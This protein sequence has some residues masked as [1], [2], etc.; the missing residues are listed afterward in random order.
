LLSRFRS[1]FSRRQF[2]KHFGMAGITTSVVPAFAAIRGSRSGDSVSAGLSARDRPSSQRACFMTSAQGGLVAA[3]YSP[4]E[5]HISLQGAVVH[6]VEE[7]EYPFRGTIKMTVSP[8]RPLRFPFLL[9][10]PFLGRRCRDP[11]KWTAG[12]RG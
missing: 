7:T 6:V 11:R 10:V 12:E 8:S 9:R 2:V 4:C 3:A 5:A 1:S